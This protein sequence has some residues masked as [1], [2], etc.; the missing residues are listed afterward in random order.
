MDEFFFDSKKN[1]LYRN[2]VDSFFIDCLTRNKSMA[3]SHYHPYLEFLF[4]TKGVL[5]TFVEHRLFSLE[6]GELLIIPPA[7]LHRTQYDKNYPVSRITLSCTK[8]YLLSLDSTLNDSFINKNFIL[9][10]ISFRQK[11][12]EIT[13]MFLRLQKLQNEKPDE[14]MNIQQSSFLEEKG[15]VMQI[16]SWIL[17]EKEAEDAENKNA[18][19]ENSTH[20]EKL[21]YENDS[22]T[23]PAAQKIQKTAKYIFDN[24]S[25][26]ITLEDAAAFSQMSPSYFSRK[27]LEITGF[28]FKEYLTN[29]R[30]QQAIKMLSYTKI[31]ITQT[32]LECGFSD[33]NY[34]KDVFKKKTGY[35]PKEFRKLFRGK[36]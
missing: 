29:V 31:N 22:K 25:R 24:F 4:V 23:S 30:I 12:N 21:F 9:S 7:C 1:G 20:E 28:G 19:M 11:K 5:K 15:L 10:K 32:A 35:C 14:N 27:F 16:L 26:E 36:I 2:K 18:G 8:K 17:Q 33:G 34:F 3:E 6:E 13:E